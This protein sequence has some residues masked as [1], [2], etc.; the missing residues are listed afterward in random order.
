MV[1]VSLSLLES[2]MADK[3]QKLHALLCDEGR[4]LV[5]LKFFP[6]AKAK[7]SDDLLDGAYE[8]FSRALKGEGL[9]IIPKITKESVHFS[10]LAKTK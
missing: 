8:M 7:S 5:N 3:A 10:A 4:E 6:G 1:I 9:G 2:A